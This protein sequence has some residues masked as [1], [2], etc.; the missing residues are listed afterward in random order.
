MWE[1]GKRLFVR[2]VIR[3]LVFDPHGC[4]HPLHFVNYTSIVFAIV[5]PLHATQSQFLAGLDGESHLQK[6]NGELCLLDWRTWPEI[7]WITLLCHLPDEAGCEIQVVWL[8]EEEANHA[9]GLM[10][11]MCKCLQ[12]PWNIYLL[13][14]TQ[15]SQPTTWVIIKKHIQ[16]NVMLRVYSPATIIYILVFIQCYLILLLI[17]SIIFV[18]RINM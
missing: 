11:G 14:H 15:Y 1:D 16:S 9:R 2:G 17:K 18:Y 8:R 12:A 4:I 5:K 3:W 7:R 6:G 13:K 10:G